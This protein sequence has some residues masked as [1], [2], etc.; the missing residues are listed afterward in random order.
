MDNDLNDDSN[1]EPAAAGLTNDTPLS[2]ADVVARALA[3]WRDKGRTN[4]SLVPLLEYL[5]DRVHAERVFF[6]SLG[7]GGAYRVRA[8]RNTD[9]EAVHDADRWISHFAVQRALSQGTVQFFSD[10]RSD[11]RFRT[12]GERDNAT[13]IRAIL[14]VPIGRAADDCFLYFDSRF[15]P[16]DW[17]DS[18]SGSSE[19]QPAFDFLGFWHEFDVSER[20][21]RAAERR[22]ERLRKST[23][24][25][26]S[27]RQPAA[28]VAQHSE[29]EVEFHG[30]LTRCPA[31]ITVVGELELLAKSNLSIVIEGESGTGKEVLARGIHAAS[32]RTGQ[33]VSLHCGAIPESLVEIELF[34][35]EKGAF[36][37]ADKSRTGL[38][39]LA[40]GGTLFLDDV[41]E[42]REELQNALLRVL[43]TGSYRPVSGA[44][45][46][47]SDIR[48]LSASL[49]GP[50]GEHA[51]STLRHDLFYR[52]AGARFR[53]PPLR[54]R[55]EDIVLLA[56]LFYDRHRS[57]DD[58]AWVAPVIEGAMLAYDWPGNCRE[59]DNLLLRMVALGAD[60]FDV[61][62]FEEITGFRPA[63]TAPASRTDIKSVV[64]RAEREVILRALRENDGNKS[65]AARSL[66]LS[67]KTL[68]RRMEKHGIPL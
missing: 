23:E 51:T 17:R 27:G 21:V 5:L 64:D 54:E 34:G 16:I 49:I 46:E 18:D 55:S 31:L 13:R 36:T 30:F 29:R 12:E 41:G 45:E 61:K 47:T 58:P 3:S 44:K 53:I 68:Y 14:V 43:E 59:L 6:V 9:G 65:L 8:A 56:K 33:F 22:L 37:G 2:G 40:R 67:R 10:T 66:G 57:S 50:E 39:E 62:R 7:S 63:E 38:L 35:H 1:A 52:L 48:V 42:M 26:T 32:G 20:A 60:S 15:R 4:E 11:R 25:A 19:F 24:Q 28:K